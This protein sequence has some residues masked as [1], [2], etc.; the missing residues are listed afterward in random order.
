MHRLEILSILR[1]FGDYFPVTIEIFPCVPSSRLITNEDTARHVSVSSR[2]SYWLVRNRPVALINFKIHL[3][4]HCIRNASPMSVRR[5]SRGHPCAIFFLICVFDQIEH[6][7]RKYVNRINISQGIWPSKHENNQKPRQ[8]CSCIPKPIFLFYVENIEF[9][10]EISK[11]V[12]GV[13]ADT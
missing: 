13:P 4:S 3:P 12:L 1:F 6:S 2:T 7:V 9:K 11:R 10:F 8:Q 5:D